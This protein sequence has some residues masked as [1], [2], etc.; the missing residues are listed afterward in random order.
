MPSVRSLAA[1]LSLGLLFHPWPATA[2]GPGDGVVIAHARMRG[3][4]V[5]VYRIAELQAA[6][7]PQGMDGFA[8]RVAYA[9][10]AWTRQNGVEASGNLCRTPDGARWGTVLVTVHAHAVSPRTNACP[11][12]MRATGVD[13]H[14][15]PQRQRYA[16]NRIDRLFLGDGLRYQSQIATRPDRFSAADYAHPGY[17]VGRIWL[18]YQ[19]RDD[20]DRRVWNMG[21][22]QPV[23]EPLGLRTAGPVSFHHAAGSAGGEP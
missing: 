22:P 19:Q 5:P 11:A 17:L 15:H 23:P 18:H 13:I 7:T 2:A 4:D 12:G 3:Q 9:L 16:V 21:K 8:I 20:Q 1:L 6:D 14:S 10:Q